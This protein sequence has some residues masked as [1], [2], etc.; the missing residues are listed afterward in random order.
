MILN[1][2]QER[3]IDELM[4]YAQEKYP[5]V[6]LNAITESPSDEKH[7]WVTVE[8][9]DWDDDD[10]VMDFTEYL[11]LKEEDILVEYGYPISVMPIP[12][13]KSADQ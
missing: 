10:R 1:H 12:M 11:S 2:V 9:I 13:R 5:E 7:V 3:L 8:G 4:A 6:K